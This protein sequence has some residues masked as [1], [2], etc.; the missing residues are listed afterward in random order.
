LNKSLIEVDKVTLADIDA[1]IIQTLLPAVDTTV[2]TQ[3]PDTSAQPMDIRIGEVNLRNIHAGYE[4]QAI[5]QQIT[6]VI[7]RS[8]LIADE[9]NLS[10]RRILLEEFLLEESF[11]TFHRLPSNYVEPVSAADTAVSNSEE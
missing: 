6:L 9:I 8:L 2:V 7:G 4:Q 3:E 11:F 1:R 5:G 10:A